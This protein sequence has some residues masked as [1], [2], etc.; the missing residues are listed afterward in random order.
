MYK[1]E[2]DNT[3]IHNQIHTSEYAQKTFPFEFATYS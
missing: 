1:Y 2:N 3:N